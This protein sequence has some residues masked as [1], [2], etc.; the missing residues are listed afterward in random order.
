MCVCFFCSIKVLMVIMD[1]CISLQSGS[2]SLNLYYAGSQ[3]EDT[4]I[5]FE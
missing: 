3:A 1:P 2:L 5:H 4:G